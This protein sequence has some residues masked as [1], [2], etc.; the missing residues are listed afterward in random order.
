MDPLYHYDIDTLIR[1]VQREVR[2]RE[3]LY[4]ELVA[5]GSMTPDEATIE[6]DMMVRVAERLIQVRNQ[7]VTS[8]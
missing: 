1:C 5:E 6:I 8:L 4:P 7:K 2:M 3:S